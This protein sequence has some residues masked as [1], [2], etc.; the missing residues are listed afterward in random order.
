AVVHGLHVS[1]DNGYLDC[2]SEYLAEM[3]IRL[4]FQSLR[5]DNSFI[6]QCIEESR[7]MIDEIQIKVEKNFIVV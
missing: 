2:S 6:D 7:G 1:R 4:L 5:F 3:E